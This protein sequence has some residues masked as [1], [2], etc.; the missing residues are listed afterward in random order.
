MAVGD[1]VLRLFVP[2]VSA[3]IGSAVST[4]SSCGSGTGIAFG[5]CALGGAFVG[6]AIGASIPMALDGAL[7]A[8]RTRWVDSA[9]AAAA[10][11]WFAV[12]AGPHRASLIVATQF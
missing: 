2:L 12:D 7:F 5:T 10:T 1:F 6:G 8:Y 9:P 3:F 4:S 11:P